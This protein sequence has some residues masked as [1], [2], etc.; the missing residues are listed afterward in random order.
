MA[1]EGWVPGSLKEYG[2]SD[3]WVPPLLLLHLPLFKILSH[4]SE[5]FAVFKIG[6]PASFGTIFR[7]KQPALPKYAEQ[8]VVL[9]R[10]FV[11]VLKIGCSP[12]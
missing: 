9:R 3:W 12:T 6:C 2:P 4:S 1:S 8:P 7:Q 11:Y 10:G 5:D